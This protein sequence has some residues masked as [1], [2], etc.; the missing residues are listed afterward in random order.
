MTSRARAR[1]P[2]RPWRGALRPILFG[3][4]VVLGGMTACGKDGPSGPSDANEARFLEQHNARF[5]DGHTIRWEN[6]PIPVFTAGIAREDEVTEWTRATGGAVT[7]TFVGSPPEHGIVFAFTDQPDICGVTNVQFNDDGKIQSSD[8]RVVSGIFRGPQCTR[9][10]Q[11]ETAHAIG[12]LDH[13]ADGTLMDP[14]GGN[15]QIT[16][17]LI[18]FFQN[19]Y[20]FSPGTRISAGEIQRGVVKRGTGGRRSVTIVDPVRR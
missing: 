12:F 19:L 14:D 20:A 15:G 17:Q 16:D 7:F 11:H 5:N 3:A 8:V 9:T 10:V 6:L 18:R 4:L 2:F 13:T 1:E